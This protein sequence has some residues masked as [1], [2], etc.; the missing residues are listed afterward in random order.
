[1]TFA[2]YRRELGSLACGGAE[3]W[4]IGGRGAI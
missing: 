2:S 1:V 4:D 3:V